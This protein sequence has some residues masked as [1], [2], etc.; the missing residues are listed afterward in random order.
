M[1]DYAR[2]IGTDYVPSYLCTSNAL[3]SIREKFQRTACTRT[4]NEFMYLV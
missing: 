1:D 3:F 4:R 2:E